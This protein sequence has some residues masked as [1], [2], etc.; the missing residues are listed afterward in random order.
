[1]GVVAVLDYIKLDGV[2]FELDTNPEIDAAAEIPQ[3]LFQA[4]D[5]GSFWQTW[6][7]RSFHNGERRTRI[8]T[9]EQVDEMTYDD[10]EGIDVST[11]GELK[12]Q[13]DLTRTGGLTVSSANLPM[14]VANNGTTVIIGHAAL[15][16][17]YVTTFDGTTTWTGRVTPNAA[18]VTDLCVGVGQNIYGIQGT[19][20]IKS[21]NNGETWA[22]DATSGVPTTMVGLTV[23]AGYLYALLPGS[24]V[25]YDG[26]AWQNATTAFGGDYICTYQEQ[27][28]FADDNII[29]RYNGTSAYE[30]DR[31]PQGFVITGLFPYRNILF[32]PGFFPVQGGKKGAVYYILDGRD[33]HLYNVGSYDGSSNYTIS[34]IAGSDDEVYIANQK[35]GGADRYDMSDGGLSS[36]PAWRGAGV[37]PFKSMAYANGKLLIGRYDGVA[38]T[39]GVYVANVTIPT[40]YETTGWLTTS[41]FDW[42]LPND[43][44]VM[45]R[46]V[47]NHDA[48]VAGQN[49]KVE[50][51]V[52]KGIT[53]T[54]AG[55]SDI[56]GATSREFKTAFAR[57][58]SCKL[59][60]TLTGPGTSTPTV[61]YVRVDAAPMSEARSLFDYNF[62]LYL[63]NQGRQKIQKLRELNKTR[64]VFDHEDLWGDKYSVIFEYLKIVPLKGNKSSAHVFCRLREI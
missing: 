58:R 50:Y 18:A 45:S 51:S 2:K 42:F 43:F 26:A 12:L 20:I 28:Y 33:A 62:A 56:V 44:K 59:R 30:A 64:A 29:Y 63:P 32:I 24:L 21:A 55:Y 5:E 17:K 6:E 48:L 40:A 16:G 37:I 52:D 41:E 19:N 3:K 11:W 13:P 47:L 38:G 9:K 27:V 46:I 34:A 31:L 61:T 36:G 7:L 23:C 1:M 8:I 60:L 49:V 10:G 22:N 53:Y 15:D 25:Y 35:R 54:L 4:Q 14:V 39:D 57:G